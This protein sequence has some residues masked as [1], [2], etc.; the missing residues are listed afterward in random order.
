[1]CN[2]YSVYIFI[3]SNCPF[4][5]KSM[6]VIY[7]CVKIKIV[8]KIIDCFTQIT[9]FNESERMGIKVGFVSELTVLL[10]LQNLMNQNGWASKS[11]L[12]RKFAYLQTCRGLGQSNCLLV[13]QV[14]KSRWT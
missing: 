4:R 8:S 13:I 7:Q 5:Q 12:F 3:A 11:V 9:K 2:N 14:G 6:Y 10:K 1:L